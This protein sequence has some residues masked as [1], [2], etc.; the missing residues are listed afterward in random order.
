M[1]INILNWIYVLDCFK[2]YVN[3]FHLHQFLFLGPLHNGCH[4]VRLA[5][6]RAVV[7][8]QVRYLVP[9]AP[10]LPCI[11]VRWRPGPLPRDF[12]NGDA[13][14]NHWSVR[15]PWS[16]NLLVSSKREVLVH[17]FKWIY[18]ILVTTYQCHQRL[19]TI[20]C[21]LLSRIYWEK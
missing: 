3:Y 14:G 18:L 8:R 7:P 20:E 9:L 4:A 12:R 13:Q 1:E 6:A 2:F 5:C 15:D 21:V 16:T 11:C 17:F 19:D 10:D